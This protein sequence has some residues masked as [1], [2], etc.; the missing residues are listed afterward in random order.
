VYLL[1]WGS[2]FIPPLPGKT[3][4]SKLRLKTVWKLNLGK[5]EGK[6]KKSEEW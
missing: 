5:G 3:S 2:N 1:L 4:T 6:K